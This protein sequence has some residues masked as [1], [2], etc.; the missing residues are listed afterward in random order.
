MEAIGKGRERKAKG[1]KGMEEWKNTCE[2]NV[3]T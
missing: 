2:G 3:L 1:G